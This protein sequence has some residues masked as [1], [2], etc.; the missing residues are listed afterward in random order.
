MA[1]VEVI[2]AVTTSDE[3]FQLGLEF[4]GS[5]GKKPV[6]TRDSAGFIVNRLLIPYMLDA[7]RAYE[8]GV[9]SI[10]EIDAAMKA[11]AGH[12][13][14]PLTLSDFVGLDTIGA[15]CDVLFDE[16]RERRFARPPLLRKMLV[17]GL[18]RPQVRHGLLRLLGRGAGPEPRD[19][20]AG[21]LELLRPPPHR[22]PLIAAGAVLV[23]V[24]VALEEIRLD[25]ELP[26][27]V[28]LVILAL[29]SGAIYALGIQV[30]QEG[31]PYAFQSVLLV[32]GL[33]LLVPAL[34]TLADVLGADFDELP[35]RRARV[36]LAAARRRR[37]VAGGR[38]AARRSAR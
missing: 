9:G 22:G 26:T 18:V 33:L 31:R 34:L 7:I 29:A 24:G 13:M 23:T 17:G 38:R 6:Q 14:G 2:R 37:A 16:F 30:R 15:V 21:L 20:M 32:C 12:P 3:A 11:G 25:D 4:A 8:E 36:D 35:G 10:A 27:G 1:L 5:L 19:L 28:H